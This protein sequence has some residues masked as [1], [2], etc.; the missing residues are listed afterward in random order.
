[1]FFQKQ[2][3]KSKPGGEGRERR[4]GLPWE[5]RLESDRGT[6]ATMAAVG[7]NRTVRMNVLNRGRSTC[8]SVCVQV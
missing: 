6:R 1:M 4:G 3:G 8:V 5:G 7:L 2:S